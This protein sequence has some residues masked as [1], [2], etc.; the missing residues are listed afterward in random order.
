MEEG[1]AF[2]PT[3]WTRG[4]WDPNAQHAGPPAALVARAIERLDPGGELRVTRFTFEV[5]RSI[6]LEPLH[7]ECRLARPGRRVGFAEASLSSRD[8]EIARAG[9]W[10]TRPAEAEMAEV[11]LEA[12]PFPGP[13]EARP[14]PVF[15]P[16]HGPSYFGAMEWRVAGGSITEPGPAAAWMRMR[17]PLVPGEEPSPLCRVLAAADSGSGISNVLPMDRF[18]FINTELSVHLVR[19]PEGEWVCV[20]AETR[21][22]RRGIGLAESVLWDERSRIGRGSQSLLVAPR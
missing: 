10:L 4:P 21:V 3:E 9:A 5:L 11:G 19:M 8:G 7:V 15:D 12:P 14:L 18:L 1:D 6:P 22:D 13:E 17:I 20:D 2:I 16:W